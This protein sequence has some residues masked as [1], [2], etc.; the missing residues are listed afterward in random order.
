M[1][2]KKLFIIVGVVVVVLLSV[3]GFFIFNKKSTSSTPSDQTA[4]LDEDI[5]KLSP[6]DIGLKMITSPNKK[7][8]KFIISKPEGITNIEYELSY[9]ADSVGGSSEDGDAGGRINRGVAGEDT[10]DPDESSYES[11]FLDLGSC[12]SG[13]C[14]YDVGIETVNLLLKLTKTDNKVY[15]VEDSLTL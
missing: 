7:Q 15:Q 9:E 2:D 3:G 13:T 4:S 8:V 1:K 14:R 5:V 11:K 6:S 12:S 10:I